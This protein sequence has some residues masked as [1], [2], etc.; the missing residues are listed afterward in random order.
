MEELID[1]GPST[2]VRAGGGT[3]PAVGR[4]GSGGCRL[5]GHGVTASLGGGRCSDG[6]LGGRSE[7]P[8][9]TAVLGG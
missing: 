2:A 8:V 5:R 6:G 4:K 1:Y 7:R 3:P 9:R